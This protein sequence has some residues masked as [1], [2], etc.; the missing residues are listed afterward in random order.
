MS[1]FGIL[2]EGYSPSK[3]VIHYRQV[4]DKEVLLL[5]STGFHP[6]HKVTTDITK[7]TCAYCLNILMVEDDI[8]PVNDTLL[9]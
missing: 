5:C 1:G 4:V 8:I 7:I 2:R 3:Y 9:H 6:E